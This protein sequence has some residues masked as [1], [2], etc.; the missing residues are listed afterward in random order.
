MF[1]TKLSVTYEALDIIDG[2]DFV[3]GKAQHSYILIVEQVLQ[4][5]SSQMVLCKFNL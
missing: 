3:I 1:F 2:S 5:T 4:F